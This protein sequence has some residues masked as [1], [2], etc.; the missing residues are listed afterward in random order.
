[1]AILE[2]FWDPNTWEA[3]DKEY[4]IY[5]DDYETVYALVDPIDYHYLIQWRWKPKQSRISKGTKKPKVY[6]CRAVPEIIG[7]DRYENGKRYQTRVTR[8]VY[9]HTVVA[10]RA[11]LPKPQTN[12]QLIVDHRN[13]DGLDCRR[14]NLRYATQSFNARN[15]HG[16]LASM[17]EV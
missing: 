12:K 17:L 15:I 9:L 14:S 5:G 11:N 2:D 1:M 8:T 10:E 7:P 4:R 3:E 6:L 16:N 13:G